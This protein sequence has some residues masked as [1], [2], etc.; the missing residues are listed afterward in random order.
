MRY[1]VLAEDEIALIDDATMRILSTTGVT[2]YERQSQ[3]LL[4]R[5]GVRIDK[6]NSRVRIPERVVREAL[7]SA[8]SRIRLAARDPSNSIE[9][10]SGKTFYTNS[11]TGIKVLDHLTG[12]VRGSVLSDIQVFAKVADALDNVHYYGPT[13]VAHDVKGG[14][15]FLAE[16]AAALENTTKH[17][18][19]E[20]HGTNLT[21]LLVRMAQVVAGGEDEL[22][23]S[24]VVSAGGCPVSP[25][26]FDVENTEAMLEF[27]GAGMPYDVLSMAMG[28]GTSPITLAGQLA[29][30]NAEVLTGVVL[31]QL[32][33][34]GSPVIYGSVASTMDMRTGVLALGA[35]E[36]AVL[37]AAAVQMANSYGLPSL[38][39]AISTDGKLP[40]DQAMFEK[41]MTGLPPVL[42]GADV[43]FG[44]AMLSSAT[45][46]SVEQL[47][48]DD[49]IA[50]A[51]SRIKDGMAV[52]GETLALELI[53]RIGPGGDFIGTMHT[54]EHLKRDV[55]LPELADRNIAERWIG[56]GA[57]D[58]RA[59]ARER[60]QHILH[61]H[62][63]KP[64][65]REQRKE[66][67]DIL[68][69]ATRLPDA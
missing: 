52:D 9:L 33:N 21:R 15:H 29:L 13:V 50:G 42:A 11:A 6:A 64:L 36:R 19:H 48:M 44:P 39:G 57:K 10:G 7:E 27:A 46:Y 41:A 49:E 61:K 62:T 26:Q 63:V 47:V 53:D 4:G 68:K 22:R 38:V 37:N 16:T 8:P 51:L 35:P 24:P 18:T 5:E 14:S 66:I 31:C 69:A 30:T 32:V 20:A 54:L 60:V 58:M 56:L 40:G 12:E 59:K 65:D 28:G 2:I 1:E 55:W 45:T 25:L 17:V 23:K 67:D 34:A 3:E 43:I